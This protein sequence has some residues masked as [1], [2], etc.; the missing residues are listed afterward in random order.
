MTG[1]SHEQI[2]QAQQNAV[3]SGHGHTS[4]SSKHKDMGFNKNQTAILQ[5]HLQEANTGVTMQGR[6][7]SKGQ[8]G[9]H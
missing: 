5:Q 2:I 1:A 6:S 8:D 3:K 9:A 4:K 7:S